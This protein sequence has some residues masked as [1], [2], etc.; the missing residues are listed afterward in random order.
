MPYTGSGSA[1]Q[2]AQYIGPVLDQRW[3]TVFD[4][5]PTLVQHRPNVLFLLG[6]VSQLFDKSF[7]QHPHSHVSLR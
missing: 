1:S 7:P 2:Q 4:A 3:A 6:C 5:V